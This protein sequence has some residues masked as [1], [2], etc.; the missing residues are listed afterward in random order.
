VTA[1][2]A[3]RPRLIVEH[4]IVAGALTRE[5]LRILLR[6]PNSYRVGVGRQLPQVTL[7]RIWRVPQI[8]QLTAAGHSRRRRLAAREDD[9][10][11]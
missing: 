8:G 11:R 7:S 3:P 2:P 10:W 9:E 5:G 4:K 6:G 1:K